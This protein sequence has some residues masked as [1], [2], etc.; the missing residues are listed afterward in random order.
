MKQTKNGKVKDSLNFLPNQRAKRDKKRHR[1]TGHNLK[2]KNNLIPSST[3][4][5]ETKGKKKINQPLGKI[6]KSKT[7]K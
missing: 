1:S 7:Q 5:R 2:H 3:L 4:E 6:R